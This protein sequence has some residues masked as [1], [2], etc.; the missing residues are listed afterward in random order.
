[1]SLTKPRG[2]KYNLWL[3]VNWKVYRQVKK[4]F[5]DL[6]EKNLRKLYINFLKHWLM[7]KSEDGINAL[8]LDRTSV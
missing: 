6:L 8:V 3:T 7:Q 1:M 2:H 5:L 4:E